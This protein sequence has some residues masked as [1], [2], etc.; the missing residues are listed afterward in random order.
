MVNKENTSF[1]IRNFKTDTAIVAF[2]TTEQHS[3]HLPVKTDAFLAEKVCEK[4]A[5][6]V[7]AYLLPVMPFGN[8]SENMEGAG[9]VTLSSM[10]LRSVLIDIADSLFRQGFKK[11]FVV[12]FHGGNFLL[13]TTFV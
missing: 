8:S 3:S 11:I 2:G 7:K 9:T 4:A 10:T 1:E 6:E 13:K 12:N 5:K